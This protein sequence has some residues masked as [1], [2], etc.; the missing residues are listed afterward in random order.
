MRS[1]GIVA[2]RAAFERLRFELR[3]DCVSRFQS[4]ATGDD[5][6]RATG[7]HLTQEEF[8]DARCNRRRAGRSVFVVAIN[9][10]GK[11]PTRFR[12]AQVRGYPTLSS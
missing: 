2:L 1:L 7:A 11:R 6:P 9:K 12:G 3:G 8:A 10:I 4:A 5:A